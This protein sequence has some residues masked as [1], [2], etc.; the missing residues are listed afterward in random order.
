MAPP[1][2][3]H[4]VQVH[5]RAGRGRFAIE[6]VSPTGAVLVG[7]RPLARGELV[8][9]SLD[10]DGPTELAA[11]VLESEARSNQPVAVEFRGISPATRQRLERFVLQLLQA[12]DR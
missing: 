1:S 6:V 7:D 5:A 4:H 11:I 9:L 2:E 3:Q 12:R 10:L 8:T